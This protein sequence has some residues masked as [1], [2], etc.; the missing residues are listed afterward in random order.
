M[1]QGEAAT[2]A[3]DPAGDGTE[4]IQGAV[5]LTPGWAAG[6]SGPLRIPGRVGNCQIKP[7][8]RQDFPVPQV[9]CQNL[10]RQAVDFKGPTGH[11]SGSG[12]PLHPSE[13]QGWLPLQEQQAQGPGATTQVAHLPPPAH[14]SKAPQGQGIASQGKAVLRLEELIA[15][16][17]LHPLY[18]APLPSGIWLRFHKRMRAVRPQITWPL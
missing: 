7:P 17:M 11:V 9:S 14:G 3:D 5:L 6:G 18:G 13:D 10:D 4:L 2:I 15:A 12:V 1:N 16:Q 8:R